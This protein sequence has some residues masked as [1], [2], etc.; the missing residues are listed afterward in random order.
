MARSGKAGGIQRCDR[1]APAGCPKDARVQQTGRPHSR[2]ERRSA[3][4]TC[5]CIPAEPKGHLQAPWPR[6]QS[7]ERLESAL[8]GQMLATSTCVV[9]P[10]LRSTYTSPLA[11]WRWP[12]TQHCRTTRWAEEHCWQSICYG[13]PQ[14]RC[15][16]AAARGSYWCARQVFTAQPLYHMQPS[17][18]R[19]R[20]K[21]TVEKPC[22]ATHRVKK[23]NLTYLWACN[24]PHSEA[25]GHC[26][27]LCCNQG[28]QLASLALVLPCRS[29]GRLHLLCAR[30]LFRSHRAWTAF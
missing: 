14:L 22:A 18:P 17:L 11:G 12:P 23:Q 7:V 3:P 13:E 30:Q 29:A 27:R 26:R 20:N 9:S 8:G 21:Q 1:Q 10:G 24:S 4:C 25:R 15:P 5:E 28:Q 6:T 19:V 16:W 2:Q